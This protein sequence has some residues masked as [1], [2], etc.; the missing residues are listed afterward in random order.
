MSDKTYVNNQENYMRHYEDLSDYDTA[1]LTF[2][3]WM[4]TETR[5]DGMRVNIEGNTEWVETGPKKQWLQ[6]TV[7]ISDY[8][9]NSSVDIMFK[10]FSD[11][12]VIASG[13]YSGVWVD[14][15]RLT[16]ER[17]NQAPTINLTGPSS[18]IT[19][20]QGQDVV[21]SWTDRDPDDNAFIALARDTDTNSRPW[22]NDRN[23][24]WISNT[25][26][27]S[28]GSSDRYTWDT[29]GV[30]IGTYSIWGMINDADYMVFD[31][32]AGLVTVEA[33]DTS[34]PTPTTSAWSTAP[35]PTGTTSIKMYAT[36]ASDPHG[37]EYYFDCLTSGGH[38]SGW[39]SS[40][41]YEDTGLSPNTWYTYRVRTRDK[42]LNQNTGSYSTTWRA[43][44]HSDNVPP[45]IISLRGSP[46]PVGR[47]N[48]LTLTANAGD[49]DGSVIKVEFVWDSN[50]NGVFDAGTDESLGTDTSASGGW[51]WSGASSKFPVGTIRFF[52]GAMDNDLDWSDIRSGD[53]TINNAPPPKPNVTITTTDSST[54]ELPGNDPNYPDVANFRVSRSGSTSSQLVVYFTKSGSAVWPNDYV[55]NGG[56]NDLVVIPAG[57]SYADIS[58]RAVDDSIA[59]GDETIVFALDGNAAYTVRSPNSATINLIDNEKQLSHIT[60]SG[61]TAVNESSTANY[62]ARAY[63][64][65]GSNS[66]V[67]G[68]ASW[69]ENSA[70]AGITGSG[71][72]TTSSV[73]SDKPCRIT[74]AYGGK[75]DTHNITI[76]NGGEGNRSPVW[77][78]PTPNQYMSHAQDTLT[79]P[80]NAVDP[81]GNSLH[82]SSGKVKNYGDFALKKALRLSKY[83]SAWNNERGW[84]E[85]YLKKVG[86]ALYYILPSGEVY[87]WNNV[88]AKHGNIPVGT[89]STT[90][91]AKPIKWLRMKSDPPGSLNN[92]D[93]ISVTNIGNQVLVDPNHTFTGYFYVR[94]AASDGL[95]ATYDSFRVTVTNSRPVLPN[96]PNLVKQQNQ[97]PFK[98]N[99][100]ATDADG[101]TVTYAADAAPVSG[102]FA[103][104]KKL[105]LKRYI[106]AYDD[107]RGWNEKYMRSAWGALYY[108]TTEGAIYKWNGVNQEHGN[109]LIGAVDAR[110]YERPDVWLRTRLGPTTVIAKSSVKAKIINNNE[111]EVSW[112]N[113]FAGSFLAK[114][115][116][117]DGLEWV[118]DIFKVT[119]K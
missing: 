42:S 74:A 54:R 57:S 76:K 29:S 47:P 62:T 2:R 67:T 111:L 56:P 83:I 44:T 4:N 25:R 31:R 109:R 102:A 75:S 11:S 18:N 61:P 55:W 97:T 16:G 8:C 26:E 48:T 71:R 68:S 77:S 10:F 94:V 82:Y 13:E 65:D 79:V 107:H 72:L 119:V 91:Y 95:A 110:Y 7:D 99:L 17:A 96:L 15:V 104:R 63:Y 23:H 66:D 114:V 98:I 52:A 73:L 1:V 9:G 41:I 64:N 115:T 106:R 93:A 78:P 50:G 49:S 89:V 58:V 90:C 100:P 37:V 3:Y 86:G 19:V 118:G 69:S 85:K 88:E 108:V 32:A 116:A 36:S 101:D 113:S 6:A 59:E 5:Y 38:D 45:A 70:Y 12:S 51:T 60:I 21:I 40:R 117:T 14:D 27:D 84:G 35:Y 81:D 103:M 30:P 80:L 92:T 46:D 39:Q 53:V 43:E 28:D 112:L 20:E 22:D 105:G 34:P 33:P 87:R 24:T